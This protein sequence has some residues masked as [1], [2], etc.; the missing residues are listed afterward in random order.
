[1][2]RTISITS[3]KGSVNHNS[4]KFHAKNTDPERSCL[5]VH[6]MND[7][8]RD[9]YHELFDDALARYNEKQKRNDRRI[10]DYYEKIASGKQE[11]T[12][13]EIIVQVGNMKDMGAKTA[14]GQLAAAVL[15]EYMKGFQERN[16]TLRVFSA[17]LHMDEATPHLHIDFIPFITGSKRGL[18]TRVSLKKALDI[19]GFKGGTRSNTERDQWAEAEKEQLAAIMLRHGI[20]WE[21]KGTHEKH[22]SVLDFEKKERAREVAELEIKKEELEAENALFSEINEALHEQLIAVDDEIHNMQ[23]SI[24]QSK[25]EAEKARKQADRYQKRMNELAP[26]VKNMEQFAIDFSEDPDRV[27]PDAGT[28]E[29]GRSYRDKKAK[30]TVQ[31]MVKVMRSVYSAYL[32]VSRKYDNLKQRHDQIEERAD[33]LSERFHVIYAE[34]QRLKEVARDFD[35]LKSVL[36]N[37]KVDSII[38]M[39]R[40]REQTLKEQKRAERNKYYREVR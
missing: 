13:H 29:S 35:R 19:L 39:E 20:E 11:K 10:E 17:H 8:I 40:Q 31:K 28:L 22:L 4:R 26:M 38:L 33:N 23:E 9:V 18:E 24:V 16:P 6:Y 36:G 1:M 37:D 27:L 5:N 3:G 25:E 7:N 21:K 30:P 12:F 2:K 32:D 34:N 15:D 14:E